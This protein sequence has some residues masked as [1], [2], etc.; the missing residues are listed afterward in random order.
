MKLGRFMP[1]GSKPHQYHVHT[2]LVGLR[3][4]DMMNMKLMAYIHLR[5]Q[6]LNKRLDLTH[7][8][9]PNGGWRAAFL[10]GKLKELDAL[11]QKVINGEV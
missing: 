4:E 8:S 5:T 2:V 10:N 9:E 11:Y 1:T 6:D 3:K 7:M